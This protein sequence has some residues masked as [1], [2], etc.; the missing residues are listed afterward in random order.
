MNKQQR[1]S[2]CHPE[3]KHYC[4][5]LCKSCYD[6]ELRKVNPDKYR[7]RKFRKLF[8]DK[9]REQQ[10]LHYK[11]NKVYVKARVKGNRKGTRII[12]GSFSAYEW[13]TLCFA[14]GFL[15]LCCNKKFEFE[16]LSPDHVVPVAKGGS[17]YLHNIQPLC[18]PCNMH[19]HTDTVDY[20][21][22]LL[23]P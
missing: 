14:V 16:E 7:K 12:I 1:K 17:G 22:N 10:R 4:K 2:N 13:Y 23:R 5:G 6:R 21:D 8:P 18:L 20:R 3:V 9:H 15:C 11:N 19:K